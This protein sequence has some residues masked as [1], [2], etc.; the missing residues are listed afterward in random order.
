[1]SKEANESPRPTVQWPRY[2][3]D[4]P[5]VP[6]VL[7]GAGVACDWQASSGGTSATPTRQDDGS[8]SRK[9]TFSV[10]W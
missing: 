5:A 9:P 1:M 4:A 2:A 7:A 3:V 10:T 6:A 8:S